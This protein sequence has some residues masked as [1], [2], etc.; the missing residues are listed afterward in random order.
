MRGQWL[1]DFLEA[2]LD[3]LGV[4]DE[5]PTQAHASPTTTVRNR[6]ENEIILL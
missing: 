2:V 6:E 4:I 5:I 3:C 1:D